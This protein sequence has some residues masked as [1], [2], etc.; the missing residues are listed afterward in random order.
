[1]RKK[2]AIAGTVLLLSTANVVN[3]TLD[4]VSAA[5]SKTLSYTMVKQDKTNWCWAASAE[6]SVRGTY[7]YHL[8]STPSRDQWDAVEYIKGSY[9]NSG[10]T[11]IEIK[12]AADHISNNKYRW[13]SAGST[14]TFD[15]LKGRITNYVTPVIAGYYSSG[16]GHAMTCVGY[17]I[18]SSNTE[19]IKI[20]DP[21]DGTKTYTKYTSYCNGTGYKSLTYSATCWK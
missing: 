8:G 16:G 19:Y 1:M 12:I 4:I 3:T 21:W 10:G 13:S 5:S 6:N 18:D 2:I 20:Y 11:I 17:K 15:F 14:K 7:K 9:V